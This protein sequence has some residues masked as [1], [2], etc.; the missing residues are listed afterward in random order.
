MEKYL[1]SKLPLPLSSKVLKHIKSLQLSHSLTRQKMRFFC[2][3]Y[4]H[5]PSALSHFSIKELIDTPQVWYISTS[6]HAQRQQW[7]HEAYPS[8][9][10]NNETMQKRS[11]LKC[12]QCKQNKVDYYEMQI[13]GADEPM[14]VFAHCLNCG[15]QWTQ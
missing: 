10:E 11:L 6:E 3:R 9:Q 12:G 7:L 15:K 1:T 14:T 2:N 5:N 8:I 13:R 4:A